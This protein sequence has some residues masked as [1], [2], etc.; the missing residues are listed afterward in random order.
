MHGP[1]LSQAMSFLASR[2]TELPRWVWALD[3]NVVINRSDALEQA[4]GET[5]SEFPFARDG[6]VI[7]RGR[8]SLFTV[9]AS[10]DTTH[11]DTGGPAIIT[12]RTSRSSTVPPAGTMTC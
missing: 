1:A 4:Q 10:G 2:R 3:S 7:H 9:W 6:Y 11:P 8:S 12:S 5:L